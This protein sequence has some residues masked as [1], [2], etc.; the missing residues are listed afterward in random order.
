MAEIELVQKLSN[1]FRNIISREEL[2]KHPKLDWG[3]NGVGDRWCNKRFNYA[4]IYG[5][6]QKYKIYSD[7]LDDDVPE[8]ELTNF[9]NEHLG[10]KG[11]L[12][13]FVFSLKDKSKIQA[14]PISKMVRLDIL[15]Q[16]CVSCGSYSDIIPDHKNDLYNDPRVLSGKT[17]VVADFQPLCNHC[18]LQKRQVSK[19]E[20]QD[21]ALYSAKKLVRF[22]IYDFEFPWEKKV[23]DINDIHCKEDTYW[24][25]PVEFERKVYYYVKYRMPINQMIKEC[26]RRKA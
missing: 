12:G 21:Q 25:D 20:K 23:F 26:F 19:K 6:K 7:R 17:Q 14:R 9:Y 2:K 5:G 4:L 18:N 3:N 10:Q 16:S 15:S 11:T 1:N 13:I 24:Y 8:E 22:R